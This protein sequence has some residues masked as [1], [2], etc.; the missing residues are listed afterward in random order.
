MLTF[1]QIHSRP[2]YDRR[3]AVGFG[4]GVEFNLVVETI[5]VSVVKTSG[6]G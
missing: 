4:S 2:C 6:G 3:T 1:E 5:L